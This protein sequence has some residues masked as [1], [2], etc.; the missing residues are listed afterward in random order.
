M[1]FEL[2]YILKIRGLNII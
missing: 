2:M 1:V